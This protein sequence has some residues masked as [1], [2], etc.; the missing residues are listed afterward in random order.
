MIVLNFNFEKLVPASDPFG[1]TLTS[2]WS[3]SSSF[4]YHTEAKNL[5]LRQLGPTERPAEFILTKGSY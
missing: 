4:L 1:K 2:P 5:F 3:S